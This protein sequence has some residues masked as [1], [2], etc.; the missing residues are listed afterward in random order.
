[1][2]PFGVA[3]VMAPNWNDVQLFAA[4]VSLAG[5]SSDP[6]AAAW[7]G[8]QQRESIDGEWAGRWGG[9]SAGAEWAAGTAT[10]KTVGERVYILFKQGAYGHLIDARKEGN[11][12]LVGKYLN[13]QDHRDSYPGVGLIVTNERIDG[14]WTGGRWDFRRHLQRED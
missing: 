12:R 14:A 11:G 3:D 5:D 1:M 4:T 10:I 13:L 7:A 9:G 6:N 8:A 2:N